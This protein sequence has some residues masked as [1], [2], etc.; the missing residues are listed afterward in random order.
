MRQPEPIRLGNAIGAAFTNRSVLEPV[1]AHLM[2]T[3][4][5]LL[6][7]LAIIFWF[8]PR[9]LVYPLAIVFVWIAVALF[10]KAYKLYR[11]SGSDLK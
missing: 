7:A 6:V 1:E 4:G 2:I 10:Y 11:D 5:V 9:V 8:F 3:T